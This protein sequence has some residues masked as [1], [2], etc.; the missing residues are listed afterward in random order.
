MIKRVEINYRAAIDRA[1]CFIN[2]A[3]SG[4]FAAGKWYSENKTRR[5]NEWQC[6]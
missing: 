1:N 3:P 2:Y 6:Q 5:G 4:G